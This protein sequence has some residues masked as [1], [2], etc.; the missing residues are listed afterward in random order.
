MSML[1]KQNASGLT[2]LALVVGVLIALGGCG[3]AD[4]P[5]PQAPIPTTEA[6]RYIYTAIWQGDTGRLTLVPNAKGNT[7]ADA[8]LV[9]TVVGFQ[10]NDPRY[11]CLNGRMLHVWTAP[12]YPGLY[13]VQGGC[14]GGAVGIWTFPRPSS[15]PPTPSA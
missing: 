2:V 10:T 6:S 12:E 14:P 3:E 1:G 7:S 8:T 15:G 11:A 9:G 4:L 13:L 5:S